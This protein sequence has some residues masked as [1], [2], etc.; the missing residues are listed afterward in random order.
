MYTNNMLQIYA[1][2]THKI[3][4]CR[5]ILIIIFKL[6]LYISNPIMQ[7]IIIIE[8]KYSSIRLC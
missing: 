6:Y 5:N 3:M 2:Y 8:S 1:S 7:V 4:I